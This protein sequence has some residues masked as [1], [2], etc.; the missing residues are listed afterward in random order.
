MTTPDHEA[1]PERGSTPQGTSTETAAGAAGCSPPEP[2]FEDHLAELQR[3]VASLE[4]GDLGLDESLA[5]FE[6]GV[7][8]LRRCQQLLSGAEQRIELLTGFTASGEPVTRPFDA[9]ATF[10]DAS[11]PQQSS[12]S[13]GKPKRER[14]KRTSRP[15]SGAPATDDTTSEPPRLF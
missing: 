2:S 6:Q 10:P 13:A 15:S 8:L 11:A 5:R 14:S 7:G 12:E 3:I 4:R 1:Y 9:A